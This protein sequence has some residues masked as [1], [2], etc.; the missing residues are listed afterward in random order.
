MKEKID[1]IFIYSSKCHKWRIV[2]RPSVISVDFAE[3]IVLVCQQPPEESFSTPH[4]ADSFSFLIRGQHKG[5]WLIDLDV[6]TPSDHR[7]R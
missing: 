2:Y 1:K 7:L 6:K 4:M 5:Y 3:R